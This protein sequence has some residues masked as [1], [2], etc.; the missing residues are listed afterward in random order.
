MPQHLLVWT[1]L[2]HAVLSSFRPIP[3]RFNAV[4]GTQTNSSI[5]GVS[6][7]AGVRDCI[8]RF[9]SPARPFSPIRTPPL[10][11]RG[12]PFFPAGFWVRSPKL[13]PDLPSLEYTLTQQWYLFTF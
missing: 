7:F 8:F 9:A 4:L 5:T 1:R 6:S 11:A 2:V 12:P 13:N 3:F 10:V